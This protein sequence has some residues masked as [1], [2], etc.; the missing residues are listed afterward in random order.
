MIIDIVYMNA[1]WNKQLLNIDGKIQTAPLISFQRSVFVLYCS[2]TKD[3][4]CLPRASMRFTF[5]P[6]Q[7]R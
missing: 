6:K 2:C 5:H 1:F 7:G 3:M 4:H